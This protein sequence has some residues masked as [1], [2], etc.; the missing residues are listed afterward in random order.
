MHVVELASVL[1]RPLG[2][3]MHPAP[4]LERLD[5]S[6]AKDMVHG[7]PPPAESD[8]ILR[9]RVVSTSSS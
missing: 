2:V 7:R 9:D 8:P 5:Q 3:E 4:V 6:T 1:S